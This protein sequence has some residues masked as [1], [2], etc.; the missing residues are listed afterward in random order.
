MKN[1]ECFIKLCLTID[2]NFY[3]PQDIS[4]ILGFISGKWQL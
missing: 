2:Y 3:R 1:E 4:K